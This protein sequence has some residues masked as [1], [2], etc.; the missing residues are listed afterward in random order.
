[1][2][3]MLPNGAWDNSWGTR[4]Y[5]WSWWGSRTSDGCHPAYVLL[6]DHDPRF[7]EV[8]LRNLELMS[9]CTQDGLLYGGPDYFHH[10]D[11]PCIHHTFTH[12]KALATVLD[13]AGA[14]IQTTERPSLPRDEPV[15]L[16]HYPE[17]GT[18]LASKGPWRATVT[19]YDWEYVEHVQAG[20]GG[21]SGGG[22]A[23]GGALSLL[24][25]QSLGPILAASMTDYQMIEISNQQAFRDAP[26]MTLTP[27]VE[28]KA[29]K[30][31]TSLT[32]LKAI[33]TASTSAVEIHFTATGEL[34]TAGHHPVPAGGI[35]Y[36]LEYF[37]TEDAITIVAKATG[38]LP[39][40]TSLQ[41]ILPVV[42]RS[43]EAFTQSSSNS[44]SI[45]KPKG[46]L[47]VHTDAPK[48]FESIPKQRTF[49]LV[50]GL[51]AIPL[52]LALTLGTATTVQ[53][54]PSSTNIRS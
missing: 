35:F 27:R 45:T 8:A 34:L 37:I 9:A 20:G 3:F 14:K 54:K 51:E 52:T 2:E 47:T 7:R 1:M 33:L 39:S 15:G 26:H 42:S 4:N 21:E 10:G 43:T 25:H 46:I 6:S 17:V 23:S 28:L 30:T 40:S 18:Y 44:I 48:G 36:R 38:Q 12:A 32:D 11:R 49:N 53:I 31:Y 29:D 5:K 22:H 41:F 19:E 24:F 50:P 16:R 13:R